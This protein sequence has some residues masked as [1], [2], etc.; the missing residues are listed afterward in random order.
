[1]LA[2]YLSFPFP[3]VPECY[4]AVFCEFICKVDCSH[5]NPSS[6]FSN[7]LALTPYGLVI[8]LVTP[9]LVNV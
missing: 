6:K 8:K 2:F 4:L 1:M 7:L 5:F 3:H 9:L